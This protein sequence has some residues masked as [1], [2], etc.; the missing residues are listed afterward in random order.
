MRS[1]TESEIRLLRR[2]LNVVFSESELLTDEVRQELAEGFGAQVFNEYSAFEMLHIAFDCAAGHLHIAEDRCYVEI[3]D[4][5]GASVPL[6]DH[7]FGDTRRADRHADEGSDVD[8]L[9]A[10]RIP[11]SVKRRRAG[12]SLSECSG[13]GA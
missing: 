8:A 5:D 7:A 11:R 3:V 4:A 9:D 12:P 6:P 2:T 10:E 1:L 13:S